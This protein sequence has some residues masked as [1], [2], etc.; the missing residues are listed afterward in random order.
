[1]PVRW[2]PTAVAVLLVG[3]SSAPVEVKQDSKV[4]AGRDA[5]SLMTLED[6]RDVYGFEMKK[7][8]TNRSFSGPSNDVST[9]QYEGGDPLVL[10][11]MMATWSKNDN[12]MAS[13]DAF[14]ESLE[15]SIPAELKEELK[16]EKV[17]FQGLPALW[18][19]SGQLQVFNKGAMLAILAD[20]A[21]GKDKKKTV[22]TL[23]AKA[24]GRL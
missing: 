19:K 16:V 1:M 12:P 23:M 5:C 7:S 11:T 13:R 18:Q 8:D 22:E 15:K 4:A 14:V 9:C 17:E 2:I 10:A 6:M 24:L 20:P 21:A 3:C